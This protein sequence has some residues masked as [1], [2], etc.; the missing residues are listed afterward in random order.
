MYPAGAK[1]KGSNKDTT[2]AGVAIKGLNW[3]E[4]SNPLLGSTLT[5]ADYSLVGIDV[6]NPDPNK[7]ANYLVG[8]KLDKRL[9]LDK[10]YVGAGTDFGKVIT[11]GA[12][13]VD[14]GEY[15]PALDI[16]SGLAWEHLPSFIT[17]EKLTL[18][19]VYRTLEPDGRLGDISRHMA[20]RSI[21]NQQVTLMR[22]S[23]MIQKG[24][25]TEWKRIYPKAPLKL[26]T[27][28]WPGDGKT[29]LTGVDILETVK[30]APKGT[31]KSAADIM[32]AMHEFGRT[33]GGK[34]AAM[35]LHPILMYHASIAQNTNRCIYLP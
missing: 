31:F 19:V 22:I 2:S 18:H 8:K 33:T 27:F 24:F 5:P 16:R 28:T 32:I 23:E 21:I 7:L 26:H 30:A 13:L 17:F 25:P 14:A 20:T 29:I 3:A 9:P 35:H 15:I 11:R 10:V 12:A 6:D 34:G 4:F 1:L